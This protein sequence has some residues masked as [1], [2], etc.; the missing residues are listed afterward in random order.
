MLPDATY[1][2]HIYSIKWWENK[3]EGFVD[4]EKYFSFSNI[5]KDRQTWPFDKPFYLILKLAIGGN[6]GGAQG[7]DNTIFPEQLVV[8]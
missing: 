1:Q 5:G 2:F 8:D 6:W 7:L 3:I 4:D